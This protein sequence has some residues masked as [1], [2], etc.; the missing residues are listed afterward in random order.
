VDLAPAKEWIMEKR[1]TRGPF[2]CVAAS[3]VVL[4]LFACGSQGT[5]GGS[6]TKS[7]GASGAVT[8][9]VGAGG[10]GPSAGGAGGAGGGTAV[11]AVWPP[12]GYVNVTKSSIGEYALGPEISG[13]SGPAGSGGSSGDSS[14]C[15]GLFGV[16]RDFKM[17]NQP[18]GHPDFETM[19]SG[20]DTGIV[21]ATLGDDGKPVYAHEGSNSSSTTGKDEFDKWYRDVADV[22]RTFILGLHLI[23]SNGISTFSAVKPNYFFPLD[24]Q[25]FGNQGESHNFAFTTEIHTAF[26]YKGGETFSF[27]GDDDVWVFIDKKLV[28]DLGG[29]HGQQSK[30]VAIDS[31]GLTVGSSYDLAVFHAERHTSESNFQIQ[32][33]L[34]FTDCGQVNGIIY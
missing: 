26:K 15:A 22:N 14:E 6:T 9:S 8:Y 18:D 29:R 23:S 2:P 24:D 27:V 34:A 30:S 21:Q 10:S 5:I 16:V 3:L 1:G 11:T 13:T 20:L 17:G 32:T 4:L 31:L 19:P 28:I 25:G 7:G 12:P 33:T